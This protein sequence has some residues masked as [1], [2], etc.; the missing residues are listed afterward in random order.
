[1]MR[2]VIENCR[3]HPP[4]GEQ[5]RREFIRNT[6]LLA[7]VAVTGCVSGGT[8]QPKFDV[9]MAAAAYE[10]RKIGVTPG[11]TVTWRNTSD[12]NHTVTAYGS[13]IPQEARFFASGGFDS[14]ETARDAYASDRGGKLEPEDEFSH[15][16]E[17]TG[18]YPY[19]CAPHERA[20]MV[21]RVI[22]TDDPDAV[23]SKS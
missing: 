13:R 4:A 21:G 1:M 18:E 15:T 2:N 9:G 10:P 7:T 22:V 20:G 23:F 6:T 8:D 5:R 19:F 3:R 12:V 16:F 14:E 17:R 11:T